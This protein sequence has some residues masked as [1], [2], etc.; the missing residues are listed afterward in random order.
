MAQLT[1]ANGAPVA[2]NL[3]IQT[4]VDQF[5]QPGA[6]FRL[7]S[8]EAQQRLFQNTARAMNG[9]SE[10]VMGRHVFHCSLADP[11]YGLGVAEALGVTG[12]A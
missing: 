7:M 1:H 11:A 12:K 8:T 3:N 9:A 2:D 5:L 10:E 6:L 4:A